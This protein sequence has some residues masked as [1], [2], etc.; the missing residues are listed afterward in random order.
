MNTKVLEVY[1]ATEHRGGPV[2]FQLMT[3]L[4]RN[5]AL[6]RVRVEWLRAAISSEQQTADI[7]KL[8]SAGH[9]LRMIRDRLRVLEDAHE[10]L[11]RL[12]QREKKDPQ[13]EERMP[14]MS[15]PLAGNSRG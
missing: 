14:D 4:E 8:L 9:E 7:P 13:Y 10:H 5:I 1:V 2:T 6:S 15:A 11:V 3:E 12:R